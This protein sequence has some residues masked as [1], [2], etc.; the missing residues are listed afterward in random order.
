MI[1][2]IILFFSLFYSFDVIAQTGFL[3]ND[4]KLAY[5]EIGKGKHTVIVI[6]GGPCVEHQYLRPEFDG[7]S[8]VGRVIY[9]DQRGCGKSSMADSYHWRDHVEDL[10]QL[11]EFFAP[12]KRV[13]LAGSSWG[14]LLALLYAYKYPD[15]IDGLILSGLVRWPG[16][17]MDSIEY[18]EHRALSLRLVKDTV[19][20]K[21]SDLVENRIVEKILDDGSIEKFKNEIRK[22]HTINIG[23]SFAESRISLVT[24]PIV[25]SLN[26]IKIPSLIFNGPHPCKYEST[27]KKYSEILENS[28][29]V[30]IEGSCHDP[31]LAN[32]N[33]FIY[34][35]NL[36]IKELKRNKY[37]VNK[38]NEIL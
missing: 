24:A 32:P 30:T 11:I 38:L 27:I 35:S 31:W 22:P 7:L 12:N 13:F 21:T 29:I 34:K 37:R 14:S 2:I 10:K 16:K 1:K 9:Y 4:P 3:N 8:K 5:W 6:H 19:I 26:Q 18:K 28:W 17:G 33:K 20:T 36:F 15:E 25:D 23:M